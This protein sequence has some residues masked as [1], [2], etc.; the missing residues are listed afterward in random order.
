MNIIRV[1]GVQQ[2]LKKLAAVGLLVAA[3]A[4]IS[5]CNP[6]R[7]AADL[8]R[9]PEGY[10]QAQSVPPLVIPPGLESPDTR[11]ALRIPAL[12]TPDPPPRTRAQG[13]LDEPPSFVIPKPKEPEA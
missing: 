6:F 12:D 8:C 7:S 1:G 9:D 4:A 2:A 3:T 13:C 5:G 11:N 10:A